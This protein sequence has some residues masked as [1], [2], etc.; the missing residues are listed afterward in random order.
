MAH[1]IMT[2]TYEPID[3]GTL[4]FRGLECMSLTD[5]RLGLKIVLADGASERV[6]E[7]T[8]EG[9]VGYRNINESYR[10][11]TWH[12]RRPYSTEGIFLVGHSRW[13]E[14]LREESG[15]VLDHV[16]LRHYAIYTGDDCIDVATE[17]PPT[18][19]SA[20]LDS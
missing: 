16:N 6:V 8:F 11:R 19:T 17:F 4:G 9:F 15:G 3:V 2:E 13:L 10:L 5:T 14:W 1:D 7:L 12:E 18:F 20:R